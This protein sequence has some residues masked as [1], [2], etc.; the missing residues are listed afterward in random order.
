MAIILKY[1]V[2]FLLILAPILEVALVNQTFVESQGLEVSFT[3]SI[4]GGVGSS[5]EIVW[6][7]PVDLPEPTITESSDGVFTSN[8]TLSNVTA[9]FTGIYQCTR[10]YNNSLCFTGVSSNA[11][12]VVIAPPIII[13]Q[14]EVPSKVDSG[15][16]ASLYV[17]FL[18]LPSHT[19]VNCIGPDGVVFEETRMDNNTQQSIRIDIVISSLNFTHG[20]EYSCTANNSAGEITV[21]TILLVRPVVE[22]KEALAKSGDN[23]TL[24]CLVQSFP[25]PSYVWEIF[26]DSNDSDTFPDEFEFVSGSGENMMATHPFLKF[27]PVEY[28]DAGVFRCMVNI[29]GTWLFSEKTLL[30]GK[31]FHSVLKLMCLA[32]HIIICSQVLHASIAFPKELYPE[33]CRTS[34]MRC[35][36]GPLCYNGHCPNSLSLLLTI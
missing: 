15:E 23:V 17:V 12:L 27:E 33:C 26:R 5:V 1:S 35:H 13:E 22:P 4:N 14:T 3:C 24:L 36:E 2:T 7:G 31:I 29:N 6:N 18:S 16:T 11:S 20:G 34:L 25:E 9:T 28:G 10:R 21:T 8:L 32:C 30:A 19:D